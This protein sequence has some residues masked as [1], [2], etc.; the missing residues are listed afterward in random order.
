M[1]QRVADLIAE[2]LEG[3]GIKR[4]YCVPGES[5]LAL[6]DALYDS[7]AISTVVCRHE[8]GAG[9]MA[10]AE[11]KL[12]GHP[13][14]FAVT[15]GPG[16]TNGSIAIHVA[17]QD[18]AP[19]VMLVGQVSR[20]ERG[21]D[22]FQEVDYARFFGGMAKEVFEV[23]EADKMGETLA[24]AFH[25]AAS[26]VPGPVVL[27]LP[28]DLLTDTTK[29][30]MPGPFE[31][32][33][34]GTSCDHCAEVMGLLSDARRPVILAGGAM[35][36]KAGALSLLR[37]AEHH[38]IPVAAVWKNQDVFDN[39]HP[40]YAGH[41][42]FGTPE[43][44][45][46]IL[47]KSDLVIAAG[48]RLGDVAS[49]N[50][51]FPKA[52][53]PEQPLIHI[54]PDLEP[55]G[56]VFATEVGVAGDPAGFLDT[57]SDTPATSGPE[58]DAWASEMKAFVDEFMAFEP[59]EPDDGVNFGAVVCAIAAAASKDAIVVTDAG[60]FSSW[61]HRHW[62]MAPDM[63][64]L[65]TIAGAMGFGVPGAVAASLV[66]PDRM[67]IAVV[68][69]G[70]MLMTGQEIA[71]ALAHGAKPKIFISDNGIYG[72]IRSHQERHYPGR[73]SGTDLNNPD[74]TAWA[75]SFG[76][77]T[78]TIGKGDDVAGRVAA[79]LAYDGACVVHVKS[80][81]ENISAFATLSALRDS[82]A[83]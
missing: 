62:R 41:V 66:E 68:G 8:S 82:T 12:T 79:A 17:A 32:H 13:A 67:V 50:Y 69:D 72:T 10:L 83:G 74:F 4:F 34:A 78:I 58:R 19:L 15:R 52:P 75:R 38:R 18:A 73:V 71:T 14:V 3:H 39:N 2:G 30:A 54:Y 44:H 27:S 56:K 25:L 24:R 29:T 1:G 23:T 33:R 46:Q 40:L 36:G 9:F 61:V 35:R 60:N 63:H 31:V 28:E 81:V 11:A 26:G 76:M 22:A 51:Q 59:D 42:G 45:R 80:S 47:Q 65:G 70:G 55:I 53:V 49:L 5:Y 6:L 37:F 77:H 21:R 20:T 48:T 7:K 43:K 64:M 57:L 16:A